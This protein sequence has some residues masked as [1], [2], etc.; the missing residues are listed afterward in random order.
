MGTGFDCFNSRATVANTALTGEAHKNRMRL[1]GAGIGGG[2][3][4]YDKEWWHF[5][6]ENEPFRGKSFDFPVEPKGH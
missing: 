6:L 3:K 5:E 2:F 1:R 4:P